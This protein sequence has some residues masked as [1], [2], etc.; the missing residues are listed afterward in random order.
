MPKSLLLEILESRSAATLLRSTPKPE[1]VSSQ[2][3]AF[4]FLAVVE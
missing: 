1:L 2:M 4:P 3:P